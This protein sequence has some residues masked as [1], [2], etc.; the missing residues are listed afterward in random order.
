MRYFPAA[1]AQAPEKLVTF[2]LLFLLLTTAAAGVTGVIAG[3]DWSA[4]WKGLFYGLLIGWGLAIFQQ[5]AWISLPLIGASGICYA[6]LYAGGLRQKISAILYELLSIA[7][8]L[9]G[10]PTEP[11]AEPAAI[12]E[13][14][15]DLLG[16]SEVILERVQAWVHALLAG[17][18]S[19]DPVAAAFVWITLV[20]LLAAWAGWAAVAYK[21]ALLAVLPVILVSMATLAYSDSGSFTVYMMLGLTLLTVATVRHIQRETEW[22]D[23]KVAYPP[24]KGRQIGINAFAFSAVIVLFSAAVSTISIPRIKEII[25]ADRGVAVGQEGALAKS[26]GIS[27]RA[28][29]TPD[30]FDQVR[31]P[32][33]PR[34][35][36]VG[37]GPELSKRLVMTVTVED[38]LSTFGGMQLP[39]PYWRSFTYDE[40]TGHGWRTSTTSV[41]KYESD[42]MLGPGQIAHHIPLDQ[43]VHPVAG[44]ASYLYVAGQPAAV[45]QSSQAAHR[46]A[47]DLFGITLEG[48]GSY[49]ARSL[50]SAA[51]ERTLRAAGQDYP[52]WVRERYL[53]LPAEVPN[54]V[55][56]LALS[57][58]A[59]APTP[60]DRVRSIEAYLRAIPYTLD[61]PYPPQNK[62]LVE[63]FLFDLREGYC[64]YY[65]TAMVVLSRAAG[66]PAR[67][68]TGYA[69]G[70]YE[71]KTDRFSVSEADAHSWVEVYFPTVGWVPFEPT[72]G[73]PGLSLPN[74]TEA[75]PDIR[76]RVPAAQP[77][78]PQE[79]AIFPWWGLF[80]GVLASFGVL[81]IAWIGFD[82]IKMRTNPDA[83]KASEIY[84]R[85]RHFGA[86]LASSVDPGDT[87]HEYTNKLISGLEKISDN[88]ISPGF[89]SSIIEDLSAL[90]NM[91]VRA[92]FRPADGAK[93]DLSIFTQWKGLRWRLGL[94]KLMR[95]YQFG[96]AQVKNWFK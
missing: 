33:L 92:S 61:V 54:R 52:E 70:T 64:D 27:A 5:P 14:L 95:V 7:I 39:P 41:S 96:R 88:G 4:L 84:L 8:H 2:G 18:P 43:V 72:A 3:P 37:A 83:K 36:L 51:D 53:Y 16:T 47:D 60:Y 17:E 75:R 44:G 57:L 82:E 19:F 13:L 40:Y 77:D 11:G 10:S 58:T 29:A 68:A 56:E 85:L 73:R 67:F 48:S 22:D 9:P 78:M 34:D 35:F 87:P 69:S 66:V 89:I 81:G 45:N 94:M 1:R 71:I 25:T 23:L 31:H 79:G 21:Q 93:K 42:Q 76:P 59:P 65:A 38:Y 50:V 55:R 6:L 12:S 63:Y 91:I 30:T 86:Q 26:L 80:V 49:R 62:D 20:W 90:T 74:S 28:T 15:S 24:R 46:S 32:G